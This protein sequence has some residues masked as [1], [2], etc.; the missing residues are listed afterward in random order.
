MKFS[1]IIKWGFGLSIG[2]CLANTTLNIVKD[3]VL[4]RLAKDK[5]FV[6][7]EKTNNPKYY[8]ILMKYVSN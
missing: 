4:K 6:E 2:C 5:A 3:G 7:Y 1:Q 8:E